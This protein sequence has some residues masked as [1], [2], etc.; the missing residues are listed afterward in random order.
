VVVLGGGVFEALG[1]Q[2]IERVRDSAR[3]HT[4]PEVAFPDVKIGLAGLGDDAVALGAVAY[5]LRTL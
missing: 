1:E 2:L 5:A 3:A 4:F